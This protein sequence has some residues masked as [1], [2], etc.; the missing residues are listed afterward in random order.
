MNP[1]MHFDALVAV[2]RSKAAQAICDEV[3]RRVLAQLEPLREEGPV[4]EI[5]WCPDCHERRKHLNLDSGAWFC[6]GCGASGERS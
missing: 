6:F 4:I 1:L 3:A 5:H 2:G